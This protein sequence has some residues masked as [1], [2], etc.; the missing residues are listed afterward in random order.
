MITNLYSELFYR[1]LYLIVWELTRKLWV[2]KAVNHLK[3]I[4][5]SHRKNR[6]LLL[7]IEQRDNLNGQ[8]RV[9][10]GDS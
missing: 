6:H 7:Q 3:S 4:K 5:C 2:L 8:K 10:E 9:Q 1:T